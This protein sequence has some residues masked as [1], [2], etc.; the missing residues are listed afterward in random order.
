[1]S[2]ISPSADM[3]SARDEPAERG[4]A[5]QQA[6]GNRL[7]RIAAVAG[8]VLIGALLLVGFGWRS[9]ARPPAVP[10]A[11]VVDTSAPA[12]VS[13][14]GGIAKLP[15]EP[16]DGVLTMTIPRGAAAD[17]AA[18]GRGY[19]MPAVI[20]L[21]V[22]DRIVLR[23]DDDAPHMILYAFLMPGQTDERVFTAPGSEVYSSGCGLH[24][25]AILNFT[26][27]F[28]SDEGAAGSSV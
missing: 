3:R 22:G 9:V 5:H 10:P 23:N 25:A 13:V 28:V 7:P 26:T 11:P 6:R 1:M 19:E 4:A 15:S 14:G 20:S 16:V 18:G 21:K 2:A 8:L 24:A 12:G 27:I 17:Q